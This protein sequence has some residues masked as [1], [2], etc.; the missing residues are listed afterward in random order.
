MAISIDTIYQR[1]L[2]IANKEQRGYITPQ[3]FN[4]L[5]NQAQLLIF[6]EYFYEIDKR[7]DE[8]G[9]SSE[10]SDMLAFVAEKISPFKSYQASMSAVSSSTAALPAGFGHR[11]GTVFY[12]N[13]TSAI[14]VEEVGNEEIEM[15]QQTS[16]YQST[17]SRPSYVRVG[18]AIQLYPAVATPAY[19]TSNLSCNWTRRPS[20]AVWGYTVVNT[21][22]M[23]D[24]TLTTDFELHASE[25]TEMVYKVL[26]LAGIVINKPGLVS[27]ATN[28]ETALLT[29]KQ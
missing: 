21:Q 7:L 8:H 17:Q 3:E 4:L 22:A 23:Y 10:Y 16:L 26:E 14:K 29:K 9:N 11:L 27:I 5:A 12:N 20:Q 28:E 1:V 2:A 24:A 13:G 18:N 19:S 6:D 15:M 25:E